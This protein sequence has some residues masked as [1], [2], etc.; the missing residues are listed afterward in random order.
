MTPHMRESISYEREQAMNNDT[1]TLDQAVSDAA[2]GKLT[3]Q[4]SVEETPQEESQDQPQV[5]STQTPEAKEEAPKEPTP[6]QKEALEESFTH[7]DPNTLPEELKPLYKSLMKDYTQKRQTESERVRE[8]ERRL[9]EQEEQIARF[10]QTQHQ[11]PSQEE[12]Q[13]STEELANMSMEEYT[14]FLLNQAKSQIKGEI[15]QD[16]HTEQIENFNRQAQAEFVNMD[17][18]LNPDMPSQHEP[19]MTAWVSSQLDA[20]YATYV[21][22]HGT[23]IGFDYRNKATQYISEW[24]N[25]IDSVTKQRIKQ[26]TEQSKKNAEQHRRMAPP[27]TGAKSRTTDAMD[28]SDA[29]GAA[30]DDIQE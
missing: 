26:T 20:D 15:Q 27:K 2:D 7:V 9:A 25:W 30:L 23:P 1:P 6:E 16:V 5:E 10:N 11:Q 22:Q 29:I 17:A 28:L 19:R 14:Q 13:Y 18:R 24:D 4:E 8:M 21:E 3:N 12:S